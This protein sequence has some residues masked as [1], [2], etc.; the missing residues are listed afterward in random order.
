M[1][2]YKPRLGKANHYGFDADQQRTSTYTGMGHDINVHD[3]WAVESP[4][5]IQD[6]T[7]E[8]LGTTDKGVIAYRKILVEA[9]EKNAAGG[10]PLMVLD[11]AAAGA[12]TG[13]AVDRRDRPDRQLERLLA[14][15]R[16]QAPPRVGL[17]CGAPREGARV[18]ASA[19]FVERHGLWTKEQAAAARQLA[20][21]FAGHGIEVV[22]F[23]FPDQHG[24]LR[25]KTLVVA[26]AAKALFEGV[27]LTSTLLAK[28]TSHKTAFP[29][30]TRGGGFD[31][32]EMQGAAD[33]LI[34]ADPST[35]RVLP[36]LEKTGWLL[37]DAY[38]G[39]GKPVPFAT[40]ALLGNAIGKLARNRPRIHC[41]P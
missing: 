37:C 40:R 20:S 13:P 35:F 18:S 9:I 16:P 39:N 14:G 21:D 3:Q 29:V 28:D 27:A 15:S 23:S 11:E 2:D 1:P 5:P 8:H 4:G 12:L 33:F 17:G 34:V 24:V 19:S 36:W 41:R 6:R 30:F 32:P 26:E 31:M 38:F 10:K 7:R 22:R 25:G